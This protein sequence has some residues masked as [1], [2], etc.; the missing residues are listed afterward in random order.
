MIAI[1]GKI[2]EFVHRGEG[3]KEVIDLREKK[4]IAFVGS[5]GA[6]KA[7]WYHLGVIKALEEEGIGVKGYGQPYEI[8]EIVGSSAGSLFGAFVSNNFSYDTIA[9][10]LDEK[11]FHEYFFNLRPREKGKMYGL[12][13]YDVLPPNIPTFNEALQR[14]KEVLDF[15]RYGSLANDIGEYARAFIPE[16]LRTRDLEASLERVIE[17][18]GDV[19]YFGLES[20]ARELIRV[21]ALSNTDRIEKYLEN[22]LEINDF[23]QLQRERGIDM[24][25][26]ASELDR[27]RKAMFGPKR[28]PYTADPWADRYI[29]SIPIATACAASCS[30]PLI[31]RPKQLIV[32]GEKI[33]YIDGEIKKT[34]ST[35]VPRENGADLII[36]S[37]TL[38]PY[39]YE[40]R[41]GSINKYGLVGI[42]IQSVYIMVAQKIRSAWQSVAVRREIFD[43]LSTPGFQKDLE[44]V[45]KDVNSNDRKKVKKAVT[46]FLKDKICDML[47][48]DL[49]LQYL[50]FPSS[51]EIFWMDHFN[52]FPHY[53]RKLVNSGYNRAKQILND[54]YTLIK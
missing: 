39:Q 18:Y 11:P 19:D 14:A 37:H 10:F 40:E 20:I 1:A 36:I 52:I 43:Y 42:F 4:R 32:E 5:G 29:D 48:L 12:S 25:V 24:Y 53:M 23:R 13:Y 2:N 49:N 9:K 44:A 46:E 45:L 34:L 50:Y 21:P 28:S 6:A 22:V 17:D 35:H 30:L 16:F 54:N 51:S 8:S 41:W 27:P 38:E 3:E 15:K 26:I 47:Q 7:L 33:F 31:Y